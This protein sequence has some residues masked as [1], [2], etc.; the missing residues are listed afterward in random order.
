MKSRIRAI[1]G[2]DIGRLGAAWLALC[3]V[4]AMIISMFAI[5]VVSF[6]EETTGKVKVAAVG[7][8]LTE[9]YKST[10]GNKGADAY[11]A[12]LQGILG[13]G[14]EVRNFGKTG[15]TL[16]KNT[17]NSYW[18]SQE[19]TDSKSYEPNVVVI[20][21]GTNDSKN[22]IWNETNYLSQAKELVDTYTALSSKPTVYF[23]L[24]PQAYS[25]STTD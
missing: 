8:S 16:M 13:N 2:D 5:P 7:D 12:I 17:S 14:Y 6:A 23:A 18:N 11:P 24:S 9:G 22:D 10:S 4:V 3:T 21:L 1:S 15:A 20:M 19:F 25:T